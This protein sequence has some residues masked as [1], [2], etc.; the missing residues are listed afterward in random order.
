MKLQELNLFS[1]DIGLSSSND[2]VAKGIRFFTSLHTGKAVK[3][4]AWAAVGDG[5]LIESLANIRINQIEK[6]DNPVFTELTIYR[7]P[8]TENERH[9]FRKNMMLKAAEGYGWTKLPMFALDSIVTAISRLFGRKKPVFFF[10]SHAKIFSIPVC[11]QLV[12][13][14]LNKFTS[15]RILDVWGNKVEWR[16]V[17]PDY[18]EDL[19]KL[20]HNR[21]EVIYERMPKASVGVVSSLSFI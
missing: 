20:P 5:L 3:S 19:L 10:T 14:G 11:S 4:H 2:W 15:Y 13:Y 6:Y 8:L 21:A 7:I 17:S 9:S 12:V 16:V 1:G 18:F